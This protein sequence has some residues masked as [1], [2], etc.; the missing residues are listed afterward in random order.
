MKNATFKIIVAAAEKAEL[1]TMVDL[2]QIMDEAEYDKAVAAKH[3]MII[4]F[5]DGITTEA[6]DQIKKAYNAHLKAAA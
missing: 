1:I 5:E 6:Y 3:I 4:A 2:V